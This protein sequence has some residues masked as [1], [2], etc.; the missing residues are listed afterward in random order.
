MC[1]NHAVSWVSYFIANPRFQATTRC[2]R[3]VELTLTGDNSGQRSP[4]ASRAQ[5]SR[6]THVEDPQPLV[7]QVLLAP[8]RSQPRR[9]LAD[10]LIGETKCSPVH[11]EHVRRAERDK[12][13]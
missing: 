13:A 7:G 2:A 5:T 6:F 8:V 9:R 11:R 12:A 1:R 3:R 10:W 4:G